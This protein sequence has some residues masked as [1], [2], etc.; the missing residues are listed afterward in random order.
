MTRFV[1]DKCAG[2]RSGVMNN[3]YPSHCVG[4][5]DRPVI[6][7]G[8]LDPMAICQGYSFGGLEGVW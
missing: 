1:F 2:G 8:T 4:I 5:M 6:A 3:N 7:R